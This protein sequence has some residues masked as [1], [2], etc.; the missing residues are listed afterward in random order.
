MK[1]FNFNRA[2]ES[3]VSSEISLTQ[4]FVFNI[5]VLTI[6]VHIIQKVCKFYIYKSIYINIYIYIFKESNN[7]C[8]VYSVYNYQLVLA[9][10]TN[11]NHLFQKMYK[12][13]VKL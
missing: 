5:F 10:L 12:Q 8:H 7:Y 2:W 9:W 3:Y 11:Q 1:N 13:C 6:H 4:K